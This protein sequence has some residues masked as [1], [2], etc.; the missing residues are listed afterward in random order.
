MN[1]ERWFGL[2][3]DRQAGELDERESVGLEQHLAECA[4]CE[5]EAQRLSSLLALAR[6]A[7]ACG[8]DPGME[9]RVLS[10]AD[11]TGAVATRHAAAVLGETK[12]WDANTRL[13]SVLR[14]AA[15]RPVPVYAAA[16]LAAICLAAGFFS[17]RNF[18]PRASDESPAPAAQTRSA[19]ARTPV[20]ASPQGPAQAAPGAR[21][22]ETLPAK[23]AF[24]FAVAH[25]DAVCLT[26]TSLTDTL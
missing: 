22:R 26:L 13:R 24:Q 8:L 20:Q 18:A 3:L 12:P 7:G 10:A 19:P 17:G 9:A 5:A 4:R 11:S 23:G 15:R 6:E 2:I 14:F 16:C 21:P 25:S 1:C